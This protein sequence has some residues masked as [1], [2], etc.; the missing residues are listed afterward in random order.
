MTKAQIAF[1]IALPGDLAQL[2]SFVQ[3]AGLP[4]DDV[5]LGAQQ[6]LLARE[7][8]H[9]VGTVGLEVVGCDALARSLAVAP[10][11]RGK[12][13]GERLLQALAERASSQGIKALYALTI[14]AERYATARGFERIDRMDV[15]SGIAALAQFRSLCPVS[16][17]CLRQRL[18]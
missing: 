4:T 18:R 5:Q 10:D 2:R 1:S 16:A 13:I 7:G 14:T 9:L 12:G 15:P 8:E 6:Y 11:R 17:V 3:A